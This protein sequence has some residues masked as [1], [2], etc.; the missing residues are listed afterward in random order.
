MWVAS[1]LRVEHVIVAVVLLLTAGVGFSRAALQESRPTIGACLAGASI[2]LAAAWS[3][4][5]LAPNASAGTLSGRDCLRLMVGGL[6]LAVALLTRRRVLSADTAELAARE[7]R[8]LVRDLHDGMAQDLAFIA[9]HGERL[10]AELG[11]DHPLVVAAR[12]ALATCRGAIVD[13]SAASAS[14]TGDALRQ[15]ADELSSRHQVR[16]LVDADEHDDLPQDEREELVRIAREAIVNAV[17][18]GG[19]RTVVASLRTRGRRISLHVSDDGCGIEP[20]ASS[21]EGRGHGL[22]TMR[23]RAATLGGQ[24]TVK[25]RPE[26]GTRVEVVV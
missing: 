8:R 1:G 25:R 7:R 19:A 26:G 18:H 24:L 14:S 17:E 23:E 15:V 9:A 20:R 3:Y 13:L 4:E 10:A 6:I 5:L 12:R 11:P 2:L 21:G 16:I 22:L